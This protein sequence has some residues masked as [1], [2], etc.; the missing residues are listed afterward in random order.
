M[1]DTNF[2]KMLAMLS[3]Q[4]ASE[5]ISKQ[6]SDADCRQID[7]AIDLLFSG[8]SL[9]NWLAGGKLG[10]A[11][12]GAL[13]SV[14]EIIFS[15]SADNAATV[16]A[17]TSVFNHRKKW[18]TKIVS[19]PHFYELIQCPPEKRDLWQQDAE[20]KIQNAMEILKRKVSEMQG[21]VNQFCS[22]QPYSN[23][24]ERVVEKTNEHERE[25]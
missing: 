10:D 4:N 19:S 25:K 8:V 22:P 18:Q 1:S 12:L 13:D 6:L 9:R 20:T 24:C 2:D 15:I 23:A 11:W 14:R 17:R 21:D 5:Y 16:Y 3:G 7:N